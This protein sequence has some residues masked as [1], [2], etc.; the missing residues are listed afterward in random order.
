MSWFFGGNDKDNEDKSNSSFSEPV[1]TFNDTSSFGNSTNFA[2]PGSGSSGSTNSLQEK[3]QLEQ[4]R[5][6]I[7]AIMVRLTDISFEACVSKPSTS[8]SSS[9]VNC[10]QSVVFL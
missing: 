5:A 1:N 8:L 6:V 7:Q 4:Q 2:V 9:E 10:V 3:L